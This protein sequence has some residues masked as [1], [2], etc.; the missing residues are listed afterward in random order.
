MRQIDDRDLRPRGSASLMDHRPPLKEQFLLLHGPGSR[1]GV[2]DPLPFVHEDEMTAA[3]A[4]PSEFGS[5]R[6][7]H[8]SRLKTASVHDTHRHH[9]MRQRVGSSC[10]SLHDV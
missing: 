2:V 1:A 3:M 9:F 8:P 6:K 4:V 7:L 5:A 10:P